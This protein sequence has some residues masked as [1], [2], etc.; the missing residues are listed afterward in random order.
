MDK[1]L[2][3]G[4]ATGECTRTTEPRMNSLRGCVVGSARTLSDRPAK[5]QPLKVFMPGFFHGYPTWAVPSKTAGMGEPDSHRVCTVALVRITHGGAVGMRTVG[6]RT[7]T[8]QSRV[9]VSTAV[10]KADES[11]GSKYG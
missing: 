5:D 8:S 11:C 1:N 7:A 9:E 2:I 3:V 6:I 10:R 4:V